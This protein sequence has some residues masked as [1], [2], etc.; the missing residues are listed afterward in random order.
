MGCY[1]NPPTMTKEAWLR[2]NATLI[3]ADTALKALTRTT[4]PV[5]LVDNGPFTAAAVGFSRDEVEMFSSPRDVRPK[6]WYSVPRSL[7]Y[8]VSD[9]VNWERYAKPESFPEEV[10]S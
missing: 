7:A 2:A 1:I 3:T 10:A 8:Q 4:V 6:R 9:L 5:C